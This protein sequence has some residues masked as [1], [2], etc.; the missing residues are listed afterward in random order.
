MV[1]RAALWVV[2]AVLALLGVPGTA[3]AHANLVG[4]DPAAN[5]VVGSMPPE[6]ILWFTETPELRFSEVQ[7]IG[8]D[9]ER[10][11]NGDL[12]VHGAD[13]RIRGID[14]R[15][16]D[17]RVLGITTK[18]NLP[19]GTYTVVWKVLS[20]V[21]GHV[22]RGLYAFS[23]GAPSATG[24]SAASAVL[25]SGAGGPPK[26]LAVLSRWVTFAGIFVTLGFATFPV[27]IGAPAMRV[28][29]AGGEWTAARRWLAV[30][31]VVLL[32]GGTGLAL[33]LQTWTVAGTLNEAFGKPIR[34][35]ITSSRFGDIWVAR[36]VLTGLAVEG[37]VLARPWRTPEP[38]D[39]KA[40]AAW[41]PLGVAA[42][43]LPLTVSMNSHAAAGEAARL[44]TALDWLHLVA[45]GVWVGGLALFVALIAELRGLDE[46]SRARALAVAVPRFS[47][48]ALV[49]VGMLAVSG[50]YQWWRQ[51]GELGDT[52]GSGYGR[53]FLAK[54][55]LV[56]PLV[57]L[58]AFN[59][60]LVRPRL[61]VALRGALQPPV[62]A[63]HALARSVP[64]EAALAVAVLAVTAVLTETSPPVELPPVGAVTQEGILQTQTVDDLTITVSIDPGRAGQNRMD[65][66]LQDNDGD[67]R[68]VQRLIVRLT[69]LDQRLGT[70]EDDATGVH[71]THFVLEGSQLALPGRWRMDLVVRREGLRDA[72]ASFEFEVAIP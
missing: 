12:H 63:A 35:V 19:G 43:G 8:P 67:Q 62:R 22:T 21:D 6:L 2:L 23:V 48:L 24:P 33:V 66:Y 40:L 27:L 54:M 46:D 42:V 47:A 32:V 72:R 37:F 36:A 31:A 20:S 70:T 26:W 58:G 25:D 34:D 71:P 5:A 9:G 3:T 61:A 52:V 1:R 41:L 16:G 28:A 56:A 69:Y 10:A 65:F 44:G 29:R 7:V 4:S 39:R 60:V 68:A 30:A 17:P 11:D 55:A 38:G 53:I 57:A 45:G 15:P 51:L 50:A 18:P 13:P 14:A 59:L 49:A 64:A